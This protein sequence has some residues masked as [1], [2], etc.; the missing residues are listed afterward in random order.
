MARYNI[1][2]GGNKLSQSG[3]HQNA[4]VGYDNVRPTSHQPE[5]IRHILFHVNTGDR[6][7]TSEYNQLI[8][9]NNDEL[10]THVIGAGWF[11][12]GVGV[13]V[14]QAGKGKL[15]P[16]IEL[17][18]G[19]KVNLASYSTAVAAGVAAG[20]ATTAE[21]DLSKVG[22]SFFRPVKDVS[23]DTVIRE[24]LNGAGVGGLVSQYQAP[25]PEAG[26]EPEALSG[27]FGI[28]LEVVYLEDEFRCNCVAVPC[29]TDFPSPICSPDIGV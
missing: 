14:K 12:T 21:V 5:R 11:I 26:Q 19:T 18:N 2:D 1:Y 15:R 13:H 25:T 6:P 4:V 17:G 24:V 20:Y 10:N 8:I 3:D 9:E 29:P 22:Y 16:L 23:A 27:C 7:F 28:I